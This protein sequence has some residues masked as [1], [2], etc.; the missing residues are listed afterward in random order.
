[1]NRS[2]RQIGRLGPPSPTSIMEGRKSGNPDVGPPCCRDRKVNDSSDV[3]N[4]P[5]KKKKERRKKTAQASVAGPPPPPPPSENP[6]FLTLLFLL[7]VSFHFGAK[8][9]KHERI[10]TRERVLPTASSQ[11]RS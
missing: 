6:P 2:S 4:S 10:H 11:N 8:F 3:D 7:T 5:Q 9:E 1:M